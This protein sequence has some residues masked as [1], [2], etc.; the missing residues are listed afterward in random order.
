VW[1]P[2]LV[3]RWTNVVLQ[4]ERYAGGDISLLHTIHAYLFSL[5]QLLA[6]SLSCLQPYW[7]APELVL[8][9][10][11]GTKVDIWSLGI[12]AIECADKKP[13]FFDMLPMR[14]RATSLSRLLAL[15]LSALC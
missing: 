11:Y 6:L 2:S 12:T 13:P 1:R 5:T 3:E 15:A 4:P 8:E 9:Q 10:E 14:V 7:M